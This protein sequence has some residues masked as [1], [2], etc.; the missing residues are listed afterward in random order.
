[1]FH[2]Y[3]TL[4]EWSD[5]AI[6]YLVHENDQT[7]N[8]NCFDDVRN[9]IYGGQWNKLYLDKVNRK[10]FSA[11]FDATAKTWYVKVISDVRDQHFQN[12]QKTFT[13]DDTNYVTTGTAFDIPRGYR[14]YRIVVGDGTVA[15]ANSTQKWFNLPGNAELGDKIEFYYLYPSGLADSKSFVNTNGSETIIQLASPGGVIGNNSF[16]TISQN[17]YGRKISTFLL[18]ATNQWTLHR[19]M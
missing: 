19:T 9:I 15:D 14:N 4:D 18:T 12:Y 6:C 7:F 3:N 10:T 2:F 16:H 11:T 17:S 13:K 5:F 8:S 1:M